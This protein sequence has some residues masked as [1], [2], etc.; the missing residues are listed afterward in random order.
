M[1]TLRDYLVQ[2]RKVM[3]EREASIEAGTAVPNPMSCVT[4]VEGRSGVRRIRVRDFQF[5][6]D[7][8]TNFAGYDLAP[9]SP[10]YFLASLGSCVAHSVLMVAARL[11]LLLDHVEV[12]ATGTLDPR[13]GY[14][15]HEDIPVEPHDLAYSIGVRG[16]LTPDDADRLRKEVERTCPILRLVR[17]GNDIV[18]SID[19]LPAASPEPHIV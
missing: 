11:D 10:E 17:R 3:A 1:T 5:I 12:R 15:G 14:P 7:S 19:L 9:T 18:G 2:K 16:D 13:G 6:T 8:P 4:T